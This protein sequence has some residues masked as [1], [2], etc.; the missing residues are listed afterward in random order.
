MSDMNVK[1]VTLT[2]RSVYTCAQQQQRSNVIVVCDSRRALDM[3]A[4]AVPVTTLRTVVAVSQACTGS[5][6]PY[7]YLL[8]LSS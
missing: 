6:M 4:T 2:C 5:H 1:H 8:L 3:R 7:H